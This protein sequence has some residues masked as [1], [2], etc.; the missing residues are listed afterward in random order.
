MLTLVDSLCPRMTTFTRYFHWQELEC[1]GTNS[2]RA[3]HLA[4]MGSPR[5]N[6]VCSGWPNGP[7]VPC[8][9]CESSDENLA[10]LQEVAMTPAVRMK[11]TEPL[12]K[13]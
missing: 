3:S 6:P 5:R 10:A 12:L 7:A 9:S 13:M 11:A 4:L 2:T 8:E 1:S